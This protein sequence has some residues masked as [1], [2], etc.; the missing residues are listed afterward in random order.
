MGL[1]WLMVLRDTDHLK[2][3]R[4]GSRSRMLWVCCIVGRSEAEK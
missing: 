3:G 4:C 2:Q 1:F